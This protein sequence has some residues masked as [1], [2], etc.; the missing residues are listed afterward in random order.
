MFV[1]GILNG[2]CRADEEGKC[3]YVRKGKSTIDYGMVN[4][5]A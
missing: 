2:D 5:D 3:T 4:I 1:V